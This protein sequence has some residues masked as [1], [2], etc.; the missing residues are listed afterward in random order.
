MGENQKIPLKQRFYLWLAT[1]I[2]GFLIRIIRKTSR[3]YSV[4]DEYS[5]N[6]HEFGERCILASWHGSVIAPIMKHM[7]EGLVV[8]ASEHGDGE[9]I[10]RVLKSLG[11]GL[12]RGS[13]TRGGSRAM[14]EMI[15]R[16]KTPGKIAIT[17]DGPKGPYRKFKMGAVVLAQKT[18]A[19]IVPLASYSNSPFIL[20]SWDKFQIVKPFGKFV[21]VY[22]PP[23]LVESDSTPG[24]L[25]EI[26]DYV[27]QEM[28]KLDIQAET[29]FDLLKEEIEK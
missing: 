14:A 13:T 24:E 3:L 17:P 19:P 21:I 8:L 7:D 27:E 9:I 22:G 6:L 20:N 11:F 10:A 26:R 28:H 25:E 1:Y 2:A 12:I 5:Q 18:G 29:Y 4:G 16:L 15:K 23:I